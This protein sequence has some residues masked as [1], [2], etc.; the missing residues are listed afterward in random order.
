MTVGIHQPNFIPWTGY[1]HKINSCDVFVLFDDVQFPRAKTFGNRVLV[2]TNNGP[3]WITVP[4]SAKGELSNFNGIRIDNS[5]NWAAKS[6]KTIK[7]AYQKAAFFKDYFEEFETTYLTKYDL[8]FDLNFALINFAC[9]KMD[10]T[11]KLVC[12][13]HIAEAKELTGEQKIMAILK[14]LNATAYI[15]GKGAGSMRYVDAAEFER[16]NIRLMWQ[17]F[18]AK[19]YRQLWGD[20]V[21]NLSII[22]LLFNEGAAGKALIS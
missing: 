21:P 14:H 1:F 20:F 4:V 22:D 3:V 6:I 12:S 9:A 10:V 2:K 13:S 7:L 19:P 17:Q 8:L 11:T 18:E 16:S 15:S 5:H